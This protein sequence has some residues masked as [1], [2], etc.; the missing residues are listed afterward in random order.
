MNDIRKLIALNL[1][2]LD[3]LNFIHVNK[4]W[5]DYDLYFWKQLFEKHD[6][7]Y[8]K[9]DT[10]NE[11]LKLYDQSLRAVEIQINICN[12]VDNNHLVS[13]DTSLNMLNTLKYWLNIIEYEISNPH[14]EDNIINYVSIQKYNNTLYTLSLY[15]NDDDLN[16]PC[17]KNIN[18][19]QLKKILY[20]AYQHYMFEAY[21]V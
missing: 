2:A 21:Y 8:D 4:E 15:N 12:Y 9:C 13:F 20:H 10:I 16:M 6:L 19:L 1:N 7:S 14:R 18:N 5:Q 11:W 3:L 17:Y